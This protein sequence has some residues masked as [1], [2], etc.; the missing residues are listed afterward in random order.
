MVLLLWLLVSIGAAEEVL[1]RIAVDDRQQRRLNQPYL[2]VMGQK[3][4]FFDDGSL[5]GDVPKDA[6]WNNAVFIDDSVRQIFIVDGASKLGPISLDDDFGSKKTLQLRTSPSGVDID[7]NAPPMPSLSTDNL[8]MVATPITGVS[9]VPSTLVKLRIII[10]DSRRKSLKQP[11]VRVQQKGMSP[12]NLFDNGDDDA[13]IAYDY[14]W[15]GWIDVPRQQKVNLAIEDGDVAISQVELSLPAV[16]A[17]EAKFSVANMQYYKA[18]STRAMP[19]SGP[20]PITQNGQPQLELLLEVELQGMSSAKALKVVYDTTSYGLEDNGK[21]DFDTPED[22]IYCTKF[23]VPQ[24]NFVTFSVV[25]LGKQLGEVT[26]FLPQAGRGKL[27]LT[28]NKDG[29]LAQKKVTAA[30]L[31]SVVQAVGIAGTEDDKATNIDLYAQLSVSEKANYVQPEMEL[32]YF[33]KTLGRFAMT[34]RSDSVWFLQREIPIKQGLQL[35]LH[36][37]GSKQGDIWVLLPNFQ[38]GVVYLK[39]QKNSLSPELSFTHDDVPYT[40]YPP[41]QVSAVS[42]ESGQVNGNVDVDI[43]LSDVVSALQDPIL[44]WN[45][46]EKLFDVD[47]QNR[48]Q[49]KLNLPY[50]RYVYFTVIS[51]GKPYGEVFLLLPQSPKSRINLETSRVGLLLT[52]DKSTSSEQL[53]FEAQPTGDESTGS[54]Q[55]EVKMLVDDRILQKLNDPTVRVGQADVPPA[56]LRDNGEG[57]DET[58][59]DGIFASQFTV[60]R[61]EYLQVSLEDGGKP[62]GQMT[63]FLPSSNKA[64]IQL[65]TTSDSAGLKLL[66]EPQALDTV[67]SPGNEDEQSQVSTDKLAHILWVGIALFAIGFTYVRNVV[68]R[69][70][71]SEV[72]PLLSRLD[73]F[74]AQQEK[75]DETQ[76]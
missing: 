66:T 60:F 37:Q 15:V 49:V 24:T 67:D 76:S 9:G 4:A 58:A 2:S 43:L 63:V 18:L 69:K 50:Q 1:L 31:S 45:G 13:D 70:W 12:Q 53:V 28:L 41:L 20:A 54:D 22:G 71:N 51:D 57:A 34:K 19:L 16:P 56:P 32:R 65:R 29:T 47:S 73:S 6:I 26:V 52:E 23:N 55:I 42:T 74:L 11:T 10:D 35:V 46:E 8:S 39:A 17:A 30:K 62:I 64:V 25:G 27:R 33:D 21:L 40:V 75:K 36:E 59:G 48:L 5:P 38:R 61:D 72:D 44:L 14:K 3:Y 68:Y 7:K